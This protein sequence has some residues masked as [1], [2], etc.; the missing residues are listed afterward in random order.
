MPTLLTVT[1]A[2]EATGIN[3]SSIIRAIK[4]GKLQST[5]RERDDAWLVISADLFKLYPQKDKETDGTDV[6]RTM[7]ADLRKDRDAWRELASFALTKRDAST[8]KE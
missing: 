7:I 3:R 8:M 5:R 6:I 4:A 2:A 1:E